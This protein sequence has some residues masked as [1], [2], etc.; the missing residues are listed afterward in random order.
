MESLI[1][2]IFRIQK[3]ASM[4]II[5]KLTKLLNEQSM[6]VMY[7]GKERCIYRYQTVRYVKTE[8]KQYIPEEHQHK[9]GIAVEVVKNQITNTLIIPMSMHQKQSFQKPKLPHSKIWCHHCLTPFLTTYPNANIRH[10][11]HWNIISPCKK[12]PSQRKQKEFSPSH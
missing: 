8:R 11:D 10:L 12:Y 5:G 7:V 6:K 9:N 1:V 2:P 4:N 3:L